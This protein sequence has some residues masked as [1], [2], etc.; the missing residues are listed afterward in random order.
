MHV[1]TL[2]ADTQTAQKC[3]EGWLVGWLN[4]TVL[5]A[6]LATLYIFLRVNSLNSGNTSNDPIQQWAHNFC[7]LIMAAP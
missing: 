5:S 4:L 3:K 7:T 2:S 1:T 6:Q